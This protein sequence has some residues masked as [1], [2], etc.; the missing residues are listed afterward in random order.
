MILF[1]C[2]CLIKRL[3]HPNIVL[4]M[5]ISLVELDP[6]RRMSTEPLDDEVGMGMGM[7]T[8]KLSS[9]DS[10]PSKTLCILTEYLEQG[11]LADIIYGKKR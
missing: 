1:V 7:D 6:P 4:V 5:G 10:T 2:I 11:S 3:R 9:K 8:S